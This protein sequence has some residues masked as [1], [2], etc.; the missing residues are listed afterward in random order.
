MIK[1]KLKELY[2]YPLGT[3]ID[4]KNKIFYYAGNTEF[5]YKFF[6][7]YTIRFEEEIFKCTER[8]EEIYIY[9][10]NFNKKLIL[11]ILTCDLLTSIL[12]VIDESDIKYTLK[13]IDIINRIKE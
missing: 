13:Q 1:I 12:D 9:Q 6:D 7:G 4:Y 11:N 2:Q 3:K 10:F 5:G 8:E